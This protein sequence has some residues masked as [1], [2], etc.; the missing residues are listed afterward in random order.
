[1]SVEVSFFST[2][3]PDLSYAR[4]QQDLAHQIATRLL[5]VRLQRW[6]QDEDNVVNAANFYS[7]NVGRETTQAVF[8]LQLV[9]GEYQQATQGLFQFVAQLAQ[10]GFSE[11]EVNGEISRL[12]G[13]IE[14]GQDKKNY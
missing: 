9:E 10:Q 11:A 1:P 4:Y 5:N 3:E 2:F 13:V 12:Q 14:R 8:S 7:S 6:E